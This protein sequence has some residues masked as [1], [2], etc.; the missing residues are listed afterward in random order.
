MTSSKKLKA[1]VA[2]VVCAVLTFSIAFSASAN[3]YD[4]NKDY[5]DLS[6][7][8]ENDK[9]DLGFYINASEKY[10]LESVPE[11]QF[12]TSS[13]EWSAMDLLRGM[14]TGYD[15]INQIPADYFDKYIE[16]FE[17][18]V[19]EKNG[20]L[21][22]SK[23]TEYSRLILA[24][25]SLGYDV[26]NVAPHFRTGGYNGDVCDADTDGAV[27][28]SY[29]FLLKYSV[30]NSYLYKQGINGPI[31]TL[32]ALNTG[33][34]SLYTKDEL[35]A[36]LNGEDEEL[37]HKMEALN[38]TSIEDESKTV[39]ANTGKITNKGVATEGKLLD[40]ILSY[41]ITQTSGDYQ[42]VTGGWA[43]F[44]SNP[45]PDI[46]GMTLQALAPYY[47]DEDRF[48]EAMENAYY[49]DDLTASYTYE[50]LKTAV[51]NAVWIMSEK[52]AK[53][54]GYLS[55]GSINSESIAQII[56]ALTE[57]GIDPLAD[58]IYLPTIDKTCTFVKEGEEYNG[59]TTNNLIDA[60]LT[61]WANDSGSSADIGGFKHVTS[62]SDGGS[63]SGTAVNG[64]A[65]DQAT[66][67]L[68]AYDRFLKGE[69]SLYDMTDMID[70][71]Y[72][73]AV[74]NTN[75][76]T[77]DLGEMGTKDPM[78]FSSYQVVTIP[79]VDNTSDYTFNGWNT[80][81]DGSGV[82]LAAD[83]LLS[84]TDND[85]T[86][87]AM[88][89][90]NTSS[91]TSS[92]SASSTTTTTSSIPDVSSTSTSTSTSTTASV[93]ST[94][95]T[96]TSS[97]Y[98]TISRT[99]VTVPTTVAAPTTKVVNKVVLKTPKAKFSSSKKKLV[100]KYTK[101]KNTSGFQVKYKLG[102]KQVI[103]TFNTK[104]SAVK[105]IKLFKKGKYKVQIRS[106]KIVNKSRV[107][108]NWSKVKIIKVK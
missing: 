25:S 11:L 18:Y 106:F 38:I 97:N 59:V 85:I 5:N 94:T 81:K 31:W 76:L 73:E 14:Y 39:N 90:K 48:N 26:T 44:G 19:I 47:L 89:T 74:A 84:T 4:P 6:L 56:V 15:Y 36:A 69:N 10:L 46:T 61:F 22:K 95:T 28:Y 50:D 20:I 55:W 70:G 101:V 57:L 91:T 32:I 24:L 104:K 17:Q 79:S 13:G 108:S 33:Y 63:G 92:T 100:V 65:T 62:G 34:Y 68:I 88:Y 67:A 29:D 93:S 12:G 80:E 75:T 45:D 83:D 37:A 54:G 66:Y 40:Y 2:L 9:A 102:K 3:A 27:E 71:S 107:Y 1:I 16:T 49:S 52:Q 58:E 8:F 21:D 53:N 30:S 103:K 7:K 42:G 51:E 98:T 41:Q 43:L 87:Y 78:R 96:T 35:E 99:T 72:I 60:I 82:S 23:S 64:M 105:T 77:F 86:L